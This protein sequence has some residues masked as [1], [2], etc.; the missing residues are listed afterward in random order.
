MK[1][2]FYRSLAHVSQR[3]LRVTWLVVLP[4]AMGLLLAF[5]PM[6]SPAAFAATISHSTA[7]QAATTLA[8]STKLTQTGQFSV[9][10]T[11]VTTTQT[12]ATTLCKTFTSYLSFGYLGVQNEMWLKQVTY[13][14][15]NDSI[16]TYHKTTIYWGVTSA[17][18]GSGWTWP[19]VSDPYT[20]FNCYSAAANN[21]YRQ[22]SGNHEHAT[23]LF[24]NPILRD[25][26]SLTIDQYEIY[27]GWENNTFNSHICPGGC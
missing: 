11:T 20:S 27:T 24:Q 23:Q 17:G 16:V 19:T 26:A 14:C 6:A 12:S 7:S 3:R 9:T 18:A 1:P 13:W 25:E 10:S 22:C 2:L 5:T 21:T 4:L 8:S 15:Y